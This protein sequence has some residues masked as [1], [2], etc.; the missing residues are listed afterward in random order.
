MTSPRTVHLID[1]SPYVFRAWYSLPDSIAD[2]R[3]RP[4]NAVFGFATFLL[5][6]RREQAPTHLALAFDESLTDC[7]RRDLYPDYKG[8]REP[9]PPELLAQ[10]ESC[11]E[12][13][14]ALGGAAY[15][16][17]GYEA[18]DLIGTLC[19]Q[20]TRRGHRAVVVSSDKD[21]M[22]L[23]GPKVRFLDAARSKTLGPGEVRQKLG[24]W[25]DQVAELLGLAGDSVDDIPGVPGV[26]NK[27]A[28]ALLRR[29]P[30]IDE[31]YEGL[32]RVPRLSLRGAASVARRLEEHRELAFLS[33]EL[34]TISRD[35]PVKAS[36][37][38]LRLRRPDPEVVG[39]LFGRLGFEGLGRRALSEGG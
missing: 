10:F 29:F 3:G 34:A 21:L 8:S 7:F 16:C 33:R 2:A 6:Y 23:V 15:A 17:K 18:D 4:A 32:D 5:K 19:H 1:A 24:V 38:E 35:A 26:G 11:R 27:T 9:A 20:L 30:D 22:Q 31:L 28:A 25:P 36:L 12:V 13:A 14:A 37:R 39:E